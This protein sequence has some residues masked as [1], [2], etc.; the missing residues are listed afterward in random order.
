MKRFINTTTILLF[1]LF[2][3]A[4]L[5]LWKLGTIPPH[6]TSDEAAL[7][8]NAYSILKTGKDFWG[9]SLPIVFKSFGDYTPGLYVYLAAPFIGVMG[10]N[11]FSVRLPNAIFGVIIVYFVFLLARIIFEKA[12]YK[13]FEGIALFSGFLAAT[14]PWLIHFS[15]GAWVP[16]LAFCLTLIGI[17]FFSKSIEK[18]KFLIAS[19]FFFGLTLISYQ[20]AKLSTPIVVLLLGLLFFKNLI[21]FDKK[22]L[23]GSFGVGIIMSLPILISVYTGYAGR[24]TVVSAF[25]YPR[26]EV[27]IEK[28]LGQGGEKV[29]EITY[30]AFHSEPLNWVRVIAG[31]WFNHFSGR[32]LFFEGD[33]NNPRHSSINMGMF[34]LADSVLILAGLILFIRSLKNKYFLFLLFWL[35]LAP[36]PSILSR[37]PVHG[38][39]S[40][41]MAIPLIIISSLALQSFFANLSKN[42]LIRIVFL[43]FVALYFLNYIYYLDSYYVHLPKHGAKYWEFGYRE[44][45]QYLE[46]SNLNSREVI[47]QQSYAQPFIYF[48]FYDK[49]DSREFWESAVYESSSVGDVGLVSEFKNLKFRYLS[50]PFKFP[51]GTIVVADEVVAPAK[52]VTSDYSILKEVLRPDGSLAYLIMEAK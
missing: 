16:N 46:E 8:Y 52:L 43:G 31:K 9:E 48:L 39:R 20:G 36:V 34:L 41:H 18:S 19:A 15:R 44:A 17:Y 12:K 26:S 29:A 38:V 5:R 25:S 11:E 4:F 40:L 50:W 10:L 3:A 30:S 47:F 23:L 13:D 45:V 51:S 21:R 32:F 27:D 2:L 28:I 33:W 14:N 22:V 37:D 7:G 6:L 42:S 35:L 24:L 1:I 49:R